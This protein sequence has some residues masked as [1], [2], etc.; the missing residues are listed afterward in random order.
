M[1]PVDL[2]PM[3]TLDDDKQVSSDLN[4]LYK[5]IIIVN[6]NIMVKQ[7]QPGFGVVNF[8]E[9]IN[10]L[11]LLQKTVDDLIDSSSN[12]ET[13][14]RY[15]VISL[16]SLTETLKGKKGRFRHNILGKKVDYSGRSVIVPGPDL[17]INE[18]TIPRS[19]VF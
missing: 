6:N 19:M 1:L 15:N 13:S 2:R 7:D 14:S 8:D 9:Y 10:N 4:E 12:T 5:R 18:C 17:S 16:K 11:R 3:I